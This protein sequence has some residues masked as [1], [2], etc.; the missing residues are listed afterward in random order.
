MTLISRFVVLALVAGVT[1]AKADNIFADGQRLLDVCQNQNYE[2]QKGY[3]DGYIDAVADAMR[4]LQK[5]ADW[6]PPDSA[7]TPEIKTVV[8]NSLV[9]IPSIWRTYAGVTY[10]RDAIE[11]A[12]RCQ[13]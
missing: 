6:C 7:V 2:W 3:C 9:N 5:R 13:H 12:W 10:V 8:V 11:A 1:P 4:Y